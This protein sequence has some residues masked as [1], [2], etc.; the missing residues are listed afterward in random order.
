MN[1]IILVGGEGT[2]L[3]PLTSNLPKP[4]V[5]LANRPFLGYQLELLRKYGI[6]DIVFAVSYKMERIKDFY[7]DGS[8]W[9]VRIRYAIEKKPLGTGG[10]IKNAWNFSRSIGWGRGASVIFNGDTLSDMKLNRVLKTH[11]WRRADATLVLTKVEDPTKFGVVEFGLT[12]RV[13]KFVEKPGWDEVKSHWISA[14]TYIF[15]PHVF[16]MIPDYRVASVERELFPMLLEKKM[17]LFAYPSRNYWLDI[18]TPQNYLQANDDILEGRVA[19]SHPREKVGRGIKTQLPRSGTYVKPYLIGNGCTVGQDVRIEKSVIGN[20]VV[21]GKGSLLERAILWDGVRIGEGSILKG[22]I[23]G[24]NCRI[25]SHV[26]IKPGTVL[27]DN[28]RIERDSEV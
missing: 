9:G 3:R 20:G 19:I 24:R 17:R 21:L 7:K 4:M 2:R 1:A 16:E 12:W 13:K 14:G 11:R 18:G 15:E 23:L 8:H 28:T 25:G 10:A 5:P 6:R 27:G 26:H 22:C